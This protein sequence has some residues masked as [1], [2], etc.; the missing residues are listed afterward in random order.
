MPKSR[1]SIIDRQGTVYS[2][3][4]MLLTL[5]DNFAV[6]KPRKKKKKWD[7]GVWLALTPIVIGFLTAFFVKAQT[8]Q[9]KT[10]TPKLPTQGEPQTQMVEIIPEDI[11]SA[12]EVVEAAP[13]VP[14]VD[15]Y[16]ES[17]SLSEEKQKMLYDAAQEFGIPYELAVAV[18]WRESDF[19]NIYGDGGKA[20]GYFQIW[21]KWHTER[22]NRL[23]VYDLMDTEGNFR[24]GCSLLADYIKSC[25]G[26]IHK[27]LMVYNMGAGGA[28]K[29][30][31]QG[32]TSSKYSRA[33]VAYM[34]GLI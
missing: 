15:Y 25:D 3:S 28:S 29:L 9:L 7:A 33:I 17:I 24:V 34:E 4:G 5:K 16:I 22:A 14:E 10:E 1:Y 8:T 2:E 26:D 18:V 20:Y 19:E 23:G 30:W 31:R 27:A 32:I 21:P 13:A 6:E 12:P 11:E